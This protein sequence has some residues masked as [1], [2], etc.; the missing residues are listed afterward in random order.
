MINNTRPWNTGTSPKGQHLDQTGRGEPSNNRIEVVLPK[1]HNLIW[2]QN[3]ALHPF[4]PF[5]DRVDS[6]QR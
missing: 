1:E 5:G 2:V 3:V 4:G 6:K